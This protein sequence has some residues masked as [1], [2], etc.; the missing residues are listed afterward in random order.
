MTEDSGRKRRNGDSR[1]KPAKKTERAASN[2][3]RKTASAGRWAAPQAVNEIVWQWNIATA[4]VDWY[5]EIDEMLGYGRGEFPRTI[6]AREK[7]IHPDDRERVLEALDKHLRDGRPYHEE[8][9]V[10][11]KDGGVLYWLDSGVVQKDDHGKPCAMIGAISDITE[12]KQ[13]ETRL[14]YLA[15][16]PLRNPTP[17][18]EVDLDGDIH[19]T[20]PTASRLFPDLGERGLLHPW[21]ADWA[22]VVRPFRDGQTSTGL[23]ELTVGD[24]TYQQTLYYS[25]HEGF[26]RIYGFDITDRKQAE[27]ALQAANERL[28]T[29][30]E[31]LDAQTEELRAANEELREQEQALRDS[32]QRYRTV[33]DFTY[34]WEFWL[35]PDGHFEYISPSIAQIVGR[36]VEPD[37]PAADLL[38]QIVHPDDLHSRLDH[39][40][41]EQAGADACE[42]EF[43]I[44]RPDGEVRWIHHVCQPVH[45]AQGRFLGTRSSNRDVTKRKQAEQALQGANEQLQTQA[46]E[47]RAANEELQAQQEELQSQTVELKE[48][49]Q[50]LRGLNKELE[51]RV[52]ER[53]AD[54]SKANEVLRQAGVYNRSLLEASL[55]PLVTIG[56]DGKIADVNA[57]TEAVTGRSRKQLIGTDFSHC[58]TE[59]AKAQ[60]GY[61]QVFREGIVRDY[62]LEIRHKDGHITPVLYNASVYRDEG[63]Q[64][65]GVFAA[66]RDITER[67][68]AE[69]DLARHHDHLEELVR[70]QTADLHQA[71]ERLQAQAE[72]LRAQTDE[73]AA[74]NE[75]LRIGQQQ[76]R[77]SEGRLRLAQTAAGAGMWDWDIATD[78]LEWSQELFRLFGLDPREDRSNFDVWRSVLHPDDR[79][80]A[81]E[82]IA[83]AIENHAPLASEYRIVLP[84]G[85][86]RWINALGNATY[87]RD[88]KPQRMIGICID[89]T[90]QKQAEAALR[91]SEER[92]RR[93]FQEDITGDFIAQPDGTIIECNAAFAEMY[94]FADC[95]RATRH[96]VSQLNPTD[97]ADLMTRLKTERRIQGHQCVH[98]RPDRTEIHVVA[99]IVGH[100]DESGQITSVQGYLFNDTERK[101][102]EEAL[103]EAKDQLE[104]KVKERTAELEQANKRLKK[105]NQRRMRTEQSLRSEEARLDALL[106]LSQMSEAPLNEISSFTLEQAIALTDS[107][108]GFVG[109]LN[110]QETVYTLHSV[111]KDVVKECNVVGDPVHWPVSDAGIW[112]D[113][114][115]EHRTLFVNDYSQPH[116]RKKGIPAGHVPIE[117]FMVVPV[118]EGRRI[119]ALAGVGNK[120]ADYDKSDERQVALLLSGM[121]SCVQ[122][123]RAREDVQKAYDELEEKVRLR[124]A[125]LAASNVALQEEIAERK[126]REAR[127]ARLT[128]LYAVLSRVN[129]AIVRTRD[130][131]SLFIEV[132]R[133]VA[134]EGGF[135][136][137]WIGRVDDG[138]VVPT[139]SSGPA[140][141]YLKQ[142]RVKIDGKLGH[143]PTGTC[144]RDNHPV[145]ND[146]FAT[147]PSM[148][149]WKQAGLRHGFRASAA[150]PLR[151]AGK[152]VAALTL[153][154]PQPGAFDA[155]QVALLESLAA[156]VSYA[157]D[158]L[159][160]QQALHQAHENLQA[161]SEE[162]TAVNEE[163]Q[164]QSEELRTTNEELRE[165]EQALQ[166]SLYE[167][168]RTVER[169]NL[170]SDTAASLLAAEDPQAVVDSLCDRV[171]EF[172]DCQAFF[173]FLVDERAGR[174]RLNAFAGVPKKERKK[175]EW[176][177][178]GVAVCGCVARDGK[179]IIAEH[180]PDGDD[181]RVALA[182]SYG[183]KAYACHPIM[184]G[185]K[186]L[187]TL[188]FGTKTRDTFNPDEVGLM[189][190]VTDMVAIAVQ[191]Q[192][193]RHA[194]RETR[195]YLDNLF[196]HA[197]APII[198]WDPQ[199]KITRFN[200][201]FERLTGLKA[202][203]A[204]GRQIDILFPQDS[205][206]ESLAHIRNATSGKT[207]WEVIEIPIRHVDGSVRTVLWNSANVLASDDKTIV[208]TI[209]QGQDVTERKAM[210]MELRRWNEQLEQKVAERTGDLMRSIDRLQDEVAR[211]VL[212]EGKLRTNSQMLE[213]FFQHTIT[214][215]AFLDG[216]FNFVRVNE[217]YARA[218]GRQP[219][220]FVGKNHFDL[221]PH[222]ENR[223]IFEQVVQTKQP[224]RAFAKPFTYP[225][226]PQ[227]VTYWN[228]QVTPLI[229][230]FGSVQFLVL[231]LE[232]VTE[233]QKAFQELEQRTRQ[234]QHLTLELSQAEERERRRLA[235]ILHDDLQQILAAAK[236]HLG[237]LSS[238]IKT[239]D[240]AR[241]IVDQLNQ[242]LKDAIEK[243]RSL[244]HELSPAMLYQGDLGETFQWLAQQVESKHGLMVHVEPRGRV[245][246][247]SEALKAFLFRSTQEI[248]FNVVKHAKVREARLRVRRVRGQVRV[249]LA[250]QGQGFDPEALGTVGGFGLLSIRER[251]ELLGGRMK[252]RSAK[253][254]GSTFLIAVPDAQETADA[255][256]T[257][258]DGAPG[259]SPATSQPASSKPRVRVL[260]VD[261]HEVMREGLAT[262]LNEQQDMEVAGQA[263]NGREA[264]DLAYRVEPDVIIMDAAMPVMGGEEATRQ[265]K[266][267]LP[268]TRIIA[269]SMFD[270]PQMSDRM[271]N[272][273]AEVY[274]LKTAPSDELLAAIRNGQTVTGAD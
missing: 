267:Y 94:K 214:P 68:R 44:V 61:E 205:R 261:D 113:A 18:M 125:E 53:T 188:S 194:L 148:S 93:L 142:I 25:T 133:I 132:C 151:R 67:K 102:A 52:A 24:R 141:E 82:R 238:R 250:D 33:V 87:D 251:I 158:T 116:P 11:R 221:Y 161:Q 235:E 76:L 215:L 138:R 202:D 39:L 206:A 243:S 229:G 38:K 174:L 110:E 23:R 50:A 154:A 156:D 86:V 65:I 143:G 189:K 103:R 273:G 254:R 268:K 258:Q 6:E 72:E 99:N 186:V 178:F 34:D 166:A 224:Y 184:V 37:V 128:S 266:R 91:E 218:D 187:G 55:D 41:Q 126:D 245:D 85:E 101:R 259:S 130:E 90:E 80:L 112:A 163:L 111:S 118:F 122:K 21:L 71:N 60:A 240:D 31:E 265:I 62:P 70:E 203:E 140:Q 149:P 100:F 32:E 92:Y 19:Y 129:E 16:F 74:A 213:G 173:N 17:V 7:L 30:A 167:T 119:V 75:R 109:F 155:E 226:D 97:W 35:R 165:Q 49:E 244:S 264:V 108:I 220:Y 274:L 28:Q 146:D 209:A 27:Q 164:A 40:R 105:E 248:L 43:R 77:D 232:D 57:A 260:L 271:R 64:V 234:L 22:A 179:P 83:S 256:R 222:E 69:A 225:N 13:T 45:D 96:K 58:F 270:E 204:L 95:R 192:Q 150:L 14:S 236:F 180:I 15:S 198:V 162:L 107:K 249:T 4:R 123:S 117:R 20:N 36:S 89:I 124:T 10:L 106:R 185:A 29:Q 196:N 134:E 181:E 48:A 135:P 183:I 120:A 42:M 246:A 211:R 171:M 26:V 160:Q 63:G 207:R 239:D 216:H 217:A 212:A 104:I 153:Y 98:Q 2:R 169:L 197:N 170:L 175:I 242:M 253:G 159:Q 131:Q 12:P 79:A 237:I 9:R 200:H 193:A 195:D 51:Q 255:G 223:A 182:R 121:W 136:L 241:E 233:R 54:L 59:P 208:A 137:V 172:L 219:K 115:R 272:A 66:A 145:V 3:Q 191:R 230:E 201:A 190:I 114:I 269:L 176:L 227:R 144:I 252:I 263:G 5:G 152:P 228:W 231:N 88:G 84:S 78:K 157:L 46:E 139:A 56:P 247:R 210:E 73:L 8:Y 199:L 257:P 81:E 262:L 177:D 168:R 47:L 127:I 147:N 1:R